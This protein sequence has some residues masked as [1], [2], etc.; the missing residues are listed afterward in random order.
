MFKKYIIEKFLY[1]FIT[2]FLILFVIASL[3]FSITIAA[4]TSVIKINIFEFL[5]MYLLII[6]QLFF[7]ILPISF[8]ISWTLTY[9][10]MSL[11]LE[12]IVLFS[13]GINKYKIMRL[14]IITSIITSILTAFCGF[15]LMPKSKIASKIIISE[16]KGDMQVNIRPMEFGQK[17]GDW[18]VFVD[19]SLQPYRRADRQSYNRRNNKR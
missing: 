12:M 15:V 19:C 13:M 4:T 16:K 6:P 2:V 1:Q 7:Y 18:L 8:I 9:S 17:F 10:N 11:E 14:A 3:V 5:Q